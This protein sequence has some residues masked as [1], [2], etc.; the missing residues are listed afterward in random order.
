MP[1]RPDKIAPVMTEAATDT[2]QR[3]EMLRWPR[4]IPGFSKWLAW[5]WWIWLAA[6]VVNAFREPWGWY[7]TGWAALLILGGLEYLRTLRQPT[8]YLEITKDTVQAPT[9]WKSRVNISRQQLE[10]ISPTAQG[11]IIAWKRNGVSWYTEVPESWFSPE[12]WPQARTALLAWG[13]G[14]MRTRQNVVA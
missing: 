14:C 4:I 1:P 11:L 10:E 8:K 13:H 12:V 7:Q 2:T 9:D 6:L 3:F 5:A